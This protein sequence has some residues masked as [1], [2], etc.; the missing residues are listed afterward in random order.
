MSKILEVM[1]VW[2]VDLVLKAVA[3]MRVSDYAHIFEMGPS[4][5][6]WI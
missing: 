2:F 1:Q 3:R 4:F 5:S 6:Y